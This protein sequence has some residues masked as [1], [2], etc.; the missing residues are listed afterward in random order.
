MGKRLLN[1]HPVN[2]AVVIDECTE[3]VKRAARKV[4][5][6]VEVLLGKAVVTNLSETRLLGTKLDQVQTDIGRLYQGIETIESGQV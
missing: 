4:S 2:E 5:D 6:R 1:H 3:L